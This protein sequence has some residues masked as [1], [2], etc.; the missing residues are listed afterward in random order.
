VKPSCV[1]LD[2]RRFDSSS[3]V[4]FVLKIYNRQ[5]FILYVYILCKHRGLREDEVLSELHG[6]GERSPHTCKPVQKI[7]ESVQYPKEF[8]LVFF[9]QQISGSLAPDKGSPACLGEAHSVNCPEETER[10]SI[11]Y[12]P[13]IGRYI[14]H[15]VFSSDREVFHPVFSSYREVFHPVFSSDR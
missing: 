10:Y 11:L 4:G 3:L 2:R 15:P 8:H 6:R 9:V 7:K 1:L 12:F 13:R 14:F 5:T